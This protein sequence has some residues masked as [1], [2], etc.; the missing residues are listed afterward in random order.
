MFD[1][2]FVTNI[3]RLQHGSWLGLEG[4]IVLDDHTE[5]FIASL[6]IWSRGD[7]ERHWSNAARKLLADGRTA[8]VTSAF[9]FWWPM[10][11]RGPNIIV[12][13]QLLLPDSLERKFNPN[14]PLESVP[15]YSSD[16]DPGFAISE[17]YL[18]SADFEAFVA[19]RG[20]RHSDTPAARSRDGSCD[21]LP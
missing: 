6:A 9:H 13:E 15:D 20:T 1:V 2:Y 17:W 5:R 21:R 10:W 19:R 3:P 7:Y 16:T 12:H 18:Y 4:E 8:F 11:R 14:Y